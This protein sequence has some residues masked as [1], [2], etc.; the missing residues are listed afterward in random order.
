M[1][2]TPERRQLRIAC[3]LGLGA[4]IAL[5]GV[6]LFFAYYTGRDGS[7]A[8]ESFVRELRAFDAVLEE[9][10]DTAASRL[11]A[12]LDRLEKKAIGAETRLSTLKRRRNLALAAGP[13]QALLQS[14]YREAAERAAEAFPF[15]E[16]LAALAADALLLERPGGFP[17][18]LQARLRDYAGLFTETR[19]LPLALDINVL[20]GELSDPASAAAL[21][22]GGEL[23][24]AAF[25]ALDGAEREG[26]LVNAVLRSLL[27][28]DTG[29]ANSLLVTLLGS[30]AVSERAL[31]FGAEYFYD[32]NPRRAAELFSR[33]SDPVSLGRLADSL[34]LA[35]FREGAVELW[36][37]L[38][39]PQPGKPPAPTDLQVSDLQVSDLQVRSLYNLA[40]A[41]TE[42]Q[43]KFYYYGEL[44]SRAPGHVYGIMGYSRLLDTERAEGLLDGQA[45]MDP[46]LDLELLRRR[47][48]GWEILRGVAET[49]LLLGRHPREAEVYRWGAW[50]FDRQ[51]R[52]SETALL[53]RQA[54]MNG[55]DPPDFAL[56]DVFQL[57]LEGRLAEA[58]TLLGESSENTAVW[59]IPANLGLIME[60]RRSLVAA[61]DQY[62]RAAALAANPLSEAKVRLRM[63]RCLRMLGR[64][65]ESRDALERVL[66]LDGGN[67]NARLELRRLDY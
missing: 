35:G 60:S 8:R 28:A 58:E 18:E 61:L 14:A 4:S 7:S 36:A 3:Y 27:V 63:A 45:A 64:N 59:Q 12:L 16:P 22:R 30:E 19:F 38:A 5:L 17:P 33:F 66:E 52:F 43:K 39:A 13:N 56:H 26:F 24:F 34:W 51:K 55:V 53:L 67:L 50:H 46:L 62:E 15:S 25:S 21:P 32:A 57:I 1:K 65:Q 48:E 31:R 41:A 9:A 40:S 2:E 37:A 42:E 49:W 20:L 10:P 44:F 23:L 54:R 47:M 6:F 29:A 11:N